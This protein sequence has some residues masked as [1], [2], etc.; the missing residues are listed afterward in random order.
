MRRFPGVLA[1]FLAGALMAA[2]PAAGAG[3]PLRSHQWGLDMVEADAAHQISTGAGA[4]VA[5]ID[6]GVDAVHPDLAGRLLPGHDF[7][8]GD[9]TP[10]DD[11]GHGTHVTGIIAADAG[12]GVGIEGVA[13]GASILPLRALDANGDGTSTDIAHAIDYAVAHGAQV[14]NLSLGDVIPGGVLSDQDFD[15]AIGRALDAGVVVVAAAGNDGLPICEQP[16]GNGRLLCVGAVD[17]RGLRSFYSSFGVGV[18]VMAPGGSTLPFTNEDIVSTWND[19]SYQ[20]LAGTS[21]ATPHVAGVAALLVSLGLRGQS[22]VDRI[23]ATAKPGNATTLGAGIV[24]ARAAVAGLRPA[25]GAAGGGLAGSGSASTQAIHASAAISSPQRIR[26]VLR[27]GVRVRCHAGAD[28]VCA[29]T[30][31]AKGKTIARGS[32]RVKAGRTVAFYARPTRAGRRLLKRSRRLTASAVFVVPAP[33][34]V[35][36]KIAFRR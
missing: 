34:R 27:R 16:S 32:H 11:N 10:Q 26:A 31:K 7:V 30:I 19:G 15:S 20:E 3:D 24:D 21:Q 6:T 22:V 17:K 23:A 28:G 9:A 35:T 1:T 2:A 14:I 36:F 8:D 29:A 18:G 13:P 25:S 5:V 33:A 12:N 4:T